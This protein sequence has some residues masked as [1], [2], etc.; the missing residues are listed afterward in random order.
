[1][2]STEVH[3]QVARLH[4]ENINQG[5]LATLGERF[6]TQMYAA[7]DSGETSV[8]LV[9][10]REGRV[11]GFVTGASGMGAIY[12]RMLRRPLSLGVAMLPVL[13]SVSRL[14]RIFEILRYS[15]GGGLPEGVPDAELLSIAVAS[16]ARGQQVAD[17]LYQ[18]LVEHFRG[19]GLEA[20]RIIVGSA[21]EP[22]HRFYRRMGAEPIA[23]VEVHKGESSVLY[24]HQTAI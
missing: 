3:R 23:T 24:V 4:M 18:R 8:L 1:M 15:G 14:K 11:V 13:F 21:L 9:E 7:I 22:A 2:Y 12:K 17:R 6:L 19:E 20:F 16:H 5:F 10:E